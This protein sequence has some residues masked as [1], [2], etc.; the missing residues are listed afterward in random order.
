M[1]FNNSTKV[2]RLMNGTQI[3]FGTT[4]DYQYLP[5][6]IKDR[7]GNKITITNA[8]IVNGD[9]VTSNGDT[10]IDYITDTFGRKI[11]FYYESNRL[12]RIRELRNSDNPTP[13]N[14]GSYATSNSAW[15][16]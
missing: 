7:N 11:D 12:V 4:F 1:D 6:E 8:T 16:N 2:L 5:T 9:S 15:Y 3:T 14:W 10:A 13:S